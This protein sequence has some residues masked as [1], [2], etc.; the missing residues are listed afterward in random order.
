MLR[1]ALER[2]NGRRTATAPVFQLLGIGGL[3]ARER[4]GAGTASLEK[5]LDVLE[6]VGASPQG[7]GHLEL[8]G[9]LGLPRTTVY[10]I[11]S[12]L[13]ARGM[14]WR[15]PFRRVYCLG[16]RA[17]ELARQAYSMPDLV[18]AARQEL[19]ALRDFTGETTYLAALDGVDTVS[20]ERCDGAHHTRSAAVLGVRKPLYCTSQG[21]A[22][23]AKLAPEERNAIVADII[24][25][26]LT[27]HTIIDRREL[28]RELQRIA[29][30]GYAVDDEEIVPGVRCVGAPII[31]PSGK[32]R[33][34]ISVAGP[35]FRMTLERINQLG[36]EVAE[37]GRRIGAQLGATEVRTIA[38]PSSAIAGSAAVHGALPRWSQPHG[39]LFWADTEGR[40][41]RRLAHGRDQ[42]I[43]GVDSPV[44]ALERLR[45]GVLV[46]HRN[47]W[48]VVDPEGQVGGRSGWPGNELRAL[49]VR[50]GGELWGVM[51]R[52]GDC[53]VGA[54]AFAGD[55]LHKWQIAETIDAIA[56]DRQG[57]TL[58][59]IA[60]AAS[61]I[62]VMHSGSRSIHRLATMPK[63]S[64][65][66]GGLALDEEG[67]VWTALVDGWSVVRFS[68]EGQL[69]RVVALPVPR[70]TDVGFGGSRRHTLYVTTS[71]AALSRE[72]MGT[73]P[74][75]GRLFELDVE[76]T[77]I[78]GTLAS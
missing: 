3:M 63:G 42:A 71:R 61:S 10:R 68:A 5:A 70:P 6:A 9:R 73:A 40:C 36:P 4:T 60:P 22:M 46:A 67:G 72:T 32:V 51:Q 21:K 77:G 8:A 57:E 24:M 59:G 11:L 65:T 48:H 20:L 58:Y 74:L 2:E 38:E 19:R 75:S 13:V 64:G 35:A 26:P 52:D 43:A 29:E 7:I 14:V 76:S 44:T 30:R 45:E 16:A 39:C 27:A 50:P 17:I 28:R 34:A 25:K 54:L 53:F 69:H 62:L 47:G 33:G 66:P 15:D 1:W 41:V 49:C 78:P 56:W 31:D 18:A 37:V 55:F 12:T 23:L